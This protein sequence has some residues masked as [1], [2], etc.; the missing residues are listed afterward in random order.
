[1]KPGKSVRPSGAV[2]WVN[3]LSNRQV[4]FHSVCYSG[5]RDVFVCRMPCM[6]PGEPSLGT[7][8]E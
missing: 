8:R 4:I 2:G 1:M 3:R 6:F 5:G 7:L